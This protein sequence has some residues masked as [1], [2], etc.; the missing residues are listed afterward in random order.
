MTSVIIGPFAVPTGRLILLIA[1][2]VAVFAGWLMGRRRGIKVEPALTVML[3]IGVLGAR[4]V[5]VAQYLDDYLLR[6]VGMIDIRDGGFNFTAG[7]LIAGLAGLYY[8]WS[9]KLIRQPLAVAVLAGMIAWGGG[10]ALIDQLRETPEMPP[11]PPLA[12]TTIEGE[13]VNLHD[14]NDRP[15]VVNLWA[16][17]CPPCR[18][19]MPVFEAAQQREQDIVFVFVNQGEDLDRIVDYLEDDA[20]QLKNVLLDP[21]SHSSRLL[22]S[23]ALPSTYYFDAAGNMIDMHLGEVSLA[24]L[25]RSLRQLR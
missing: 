9:Q 11:L 25:N 8:A 1:F 12:L 19:E 4:L 3:L 17:W 2:L 23:R 24:T 21:Q 6:P 22:N 5:F 14:L 10:H 13:F 16:T 15:M 18:R 7:V 20:L